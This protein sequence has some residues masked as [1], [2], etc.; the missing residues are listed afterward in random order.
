[1]D[2][3]FFIQKRG[4]RDVREKKNSV[5]SYDGIPMMI[6]PL[7]NSQPLVVFVNPKSGGRQGAK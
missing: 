4:A 5:I 1:M 3:I 2:A 6:S 7:P